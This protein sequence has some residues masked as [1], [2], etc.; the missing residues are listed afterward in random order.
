MSRVCGGDVG[1]VR[2]VV[3]GMWVM[4]EKSSVMLEKQC[5]VYDGHC[6]FWLCMIGGS[7]IEFWRRRSCVR[8]IGGHSSVWL[9]MNRGGEFENWW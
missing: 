3:V 1:H 7:K 9:C 6:R 8:C 5:D 2:K 4:L